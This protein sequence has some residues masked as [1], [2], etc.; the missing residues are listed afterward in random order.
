MQT[1]NEKV[2]NRGAYTYMVRALI[3]PVLMG[4]IYFL[5][6]GKLDNQNAWFYYILFFV[7]SI[8]VNSVL[9]VKNKELLYHRS[10]TKSDAVSWDKRL[11]PIAVLT[12]FHLQNLVMGLEH[13]FSEPFTNNMAMII[14]L[15][16]YLVS[17]FITTWSMLV[18]HHF[19][20]NVRIQ[21]DRSHQVI[22]SGP[23]AI[24]R[25]PGYLSFILATFA[26][27]MIIGSYYGFLNAFLGSILL[28]IRTHMED[29]TLKEELDGYQE[30]ALITRYRIL[31]GIW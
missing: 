6:A 10:K 25:H 5:A 20:A 11:M 22:T 30:Y 8:S 28:L 12:G 13:R 3:A 24:V 4:F 14:G 31:P 21:K 15:I 1:I 18:N 29:N 27:P 19:E 2:I 9:F 7:L 26:I 17:Y 23:Y 16:L